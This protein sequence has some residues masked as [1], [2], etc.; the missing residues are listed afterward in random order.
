MT[1][2]TERQFNLITNNLGIAPDRPSQMS[3]FAE[4]CFNDNS[5]EELVDCHGAPADRTD[6]REWKITANEWHQGIKE[7]LA[8]RAAEYLSETETA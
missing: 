6:C 8:A 3:P 1:T 7:A 5:I 4:A 2:I